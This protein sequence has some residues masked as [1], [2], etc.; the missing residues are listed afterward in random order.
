M[1]IRSRRDEPEQQDAR[2]SVF[3]QLQLKGLT[4]VGNQV[5]KILENAI[6]GYDGSGYRRNYR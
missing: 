2:N 4:D 6:L 5:D 1:L 3:L